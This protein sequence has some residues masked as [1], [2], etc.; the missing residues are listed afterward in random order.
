MKNRKIALIIVVAIIIISIILYFLPLGKILSNIPLI[1]SFYNN[2]SIEIITEKG[3]AQVAIN[4]KDYGQTPTTIENLPEGRYTIELKKIADDNTFYKKQ[5]FEIELAKNTS[6][7]IDL[8]I[9]PED[10]LN[11]T[12]LYYTSVPHTTSGK[13]LVTIT[14]SATDAKVY[15]DKE[16]IGN[17]PI[18]NLE[19]K[20]NQYQIKVS[21]TGYE[22]IEIPVFVRAGYQLNLK[23]YHFPIPVNFDTVSN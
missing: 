12:I 1:K 2:T 23:T 17:A 8:E 5:I 13:G 4:N 21:A 14:S 11:G 15:V 22:D 16:Y 7:R 3:K 9:G 19:L 20:D 10:I 18:T 6:A